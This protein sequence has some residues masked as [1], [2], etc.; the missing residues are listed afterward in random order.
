MKA[1]VKRYA[2]PGIW[3]RPLYTE[4]ADIP[5]EMKLARGERRYLD[6]SHPAV[7]NMLR[8]DITRIRSWGFRLLKHDYTTFDIFGDWGV[9][10]SDTVTN[11]PNWHFYDRTKTSA[12]IVLQLYRLIREAA[13][14]MTVIGCNTVSHLCAG[15]VELNRTGDDTSGREWAR[16]L[17]MG[18]NTLAFRLAQNGAF[19]MVD[20]DC[21]GILKNNIPWEKN[22]LWMELLSKSN[23]ALFLSCC[24]VNDTQAED[25]KE[26]YRAA[27]TP[28]TIRPL[29]WMETKTPAVWEID[30]ET[31]RFD[32]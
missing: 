28:H 20:A 27:Q 25:I 15:L 6:P 13:G 5:E 7:L 22:R 9:N 19:Y 8:D 4:Q 26:A 16:T 29:D 21:V 32:W 10:L 31:V 1:L 18:V 14:D 30:G 23:T 24:E 17:K 3:I 12:Q 2:K 11:E